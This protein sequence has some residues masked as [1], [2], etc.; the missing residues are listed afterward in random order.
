MHSIQLKNIA[1]GYP[2]KPVLSSLSLTIPAGQITT[3]VG[4]NGCGKTTLLRTV[5]GLLPY[6]HGKIFFGQ[7]DKTTF[8]RREFAR[9]VSFLPQGKPTPSVTVES[10][11]LHGRYPYLNLALKPTAEDYAAAEA[12]MQ[13][14]GVLPFRNRYLSELS[15]GERQRVYFAMLI[16]QAADIL[17][18]DEP[19]T[20]LDIT[21]QFELLQ[22]IEAQKA[23]GK[24]ILMVLH[25]LSHALSYSD[26]LVVM[27][28]GSILA[29]GTPEEI[30][31][32]GCLSDV[33]HIDILSGTTQKGRRY[34][35]LLPQ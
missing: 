35:H 13:Q 19:T 24:T 23:A 14:T 7:T 1:A 3:I 33:F 10:Y 21:C 28:Q 12:A 11:V 9:L 22:L 2:D 20:Y 5:A 6:S 32:S 34:Y 18:L 25:D 15:G 27:Q 8:S 29:T 30:L 16:A 17:I 26:F 4:P 31:A